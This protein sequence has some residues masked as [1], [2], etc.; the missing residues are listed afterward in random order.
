MK[1]RTLLLMIGLI[2]CLTQGHAVLKEKDLART[3]GV[4]KAELKDTYEKQRA[5]MAIYEQQGAAQH[6]ELVQY[7]QQSEQIGLMLYSQT[8]ENTLAMAYACQQ[9]TDLY[10]ELGRKNSRMMQYDRIINTIQHEVERL[11][12]LITSLKSLP[13]ISIEDAKEV[14]TTSD[15]LLLQILDS[16]SEGQDSLIWAET[17][18]EKEEGAENTTTEEEEDEKEEEED[19]S[20]SEEDESEPLYL[21]GR[22][23]KDRAECVAYADTL[24]SNMRNFLENLEKEST[25]Y[26]SVREKVERLNTFA[27]SRY[28]MMQENIFRN[29]DRNYIRMLSRFSRY[30]RQASRSIRNK[31]SPLRGHSSRY[32]EWRG[33]SVV[34]ISVFIIQYLAIALLLGWLIIR[35]AIPKSWRS[36]EYRLKRQ[37]LTMVVGVG[38]F[39]IIVMTVRAFTDRNF[40]RMG[41]SLIINFAW[42]LEIIFLSLYIR[43]RGDQMRHAALSFMPLILVAFFVIMFRIV[44]IPNAVIILVFPM[45][46]LLTVFWQLRVSALHRNY[47]PNLDK[48]YINLTTTVIVIA[49]IASWVG[50][51]LMAVQI[52]IWWTFQIAAI[53][54]ITCLYDLMEMFKKR[55][56]IF[57]IDPTLRQK[58]K[59]GEDIVGDI[60]GLLQEMTA[61]Q[62][63]GKTWFYDLLHHTIIPVLGVLSVPFSIYRA[64]EVFEMKSLCQR[65]FF[66]DILNVPD[67]IRLSLSK[68]CLVASLWFVFSYLNYAIRS[69]YSDYRRVVSEGRTANITLAKNVIAIL[70]WGLYFITT[71]VILNVPKSG[72]SL[73]TAGLATG[74]GFAMQDLIENFFYGISLMTGRLHVGDYI[75]CDG[76]LGKVESITYQSTQIT[77]IEGNVIAFLNKSLFSK[78][79]KNLTRNH[80]YELIKVPLGVA[81]GTDV[82]LVRKVLIE[83]LTPL[84]LSKNKNGVN[85]TDIRQTP[86][87]LAFVDFG[88]SSVNLCVCIWMLVEEKI[89]LTASVKEII[90]KALNENHIQIPFPQRDLHVINLPAG[91][92]TI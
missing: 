63:F 21:R 41:T 86:L 81:Y 51:T 67:L 82:E 18:V 2:L 43:L 30:F 3:L 80:E 60:K 33:M 89:A 11:D 39:A 5:F 55:F 75:E 22:Q 37:M 83:A 73:V 57:R 48:L 68:L 10:R 50:F 32:S 92:G 47:L 7:M 54:T 42:L 69:I 38:L 4:L 76:M 27:Q 91:Q 12:E 15:S 78:N 64:A 44:L 62:H 23:L 70:V 28:K 24:R 45:L 6:K 13:P 46:L 8:Q 66:M 35:L 74:L 14:M 87:K 16:F 1:K 72:I 17:E 59:D 90:Y 88:E 58:Q 49:C 52:M 29:G 9:A 53:M 34:F 25:Y 85:L 31:Y 77:T 19:E 36:P 79:F 26:K 40:I 61:G 20:Y 56:M 71:L 84:C 65:V